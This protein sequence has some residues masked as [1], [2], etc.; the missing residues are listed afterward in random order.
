MAAGQE[1]H[2][3]QLA[4]AWASFSASLQEAQRS[5]TDP[6]YFPPAPT[7]RNLAEGHRY[8][9]AHLNRLIESELRT[10]PEFPEFFRSMDMLR[11]WTGENPDAMYLKAPIDGRVTTRSPPRWPIPGSGGIPAG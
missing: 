1:P 7:D 9:L 3:E 11:K 10:D 6:Q 2:Q 4:D 8:L 5:L